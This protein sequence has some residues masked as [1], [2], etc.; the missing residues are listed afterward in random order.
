[1]RAN[2]ARLGTLAVLLAVLAL[3]NPWGL[4]VHLTLIGLL[5]LHRLWD[6]RRPLRALL[7]AFG[8]VVALAVAAVVLS[9]PF[10][11]RF[12]AQYQGIGRVQSRTPLGPFLLV[13]GFLLVPAVA[14][15]GGD[16]VGELADDAPSR[17]LVVACAVF[18]TLALYVATQSAVLILATAVAIAALLEPAHTRPR[19]DDR[20]G[21]RAGGDRRGC[22]R[23]VRGRL[24][25]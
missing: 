2:A 11:L 23:G 15:L 21:D 16:L 9:L 25:A 10:S 1:M 13:F 4:P 22:S 5:A 20:A 19:T 7:T 18:T 12:H 24:P 6:E 17:D 3:A 14:R 8:G